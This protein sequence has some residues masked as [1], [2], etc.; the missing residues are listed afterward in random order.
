MG[1]LTSSAEYTAFVTEMNTAIKNF[2]ILHPN[3][4][5]YSKTDN[6]KSLITLFYGQERDVNL[7][8]I[9]DTI[10]TT[11]N[12][13]SFEIDG[14]PVTPIKANNNIIVFEGNTAAV[15]AAIARSNNYP[16]LKVLSDQE[17]S[18][19]VNDL[20]S[21]IINMVNKL[22]RNRS[23]IPESYLRK[24]GITID[25]NSKS[26]GRLKINASTLKAYLDE[27]N[28]EFHIVPEIDTIGA[29]NT[30]D[31][32]PSLEPPPNGYNYELIDLDNPRHKRQMECDLNNSFDERNIYVKEIVNGTD[33]YRLT[34]YSDF[35][36][37]TTENDNQPVYHFKNN[38]D[39][40]K[41]TMDQSTEEGE[42]PFNPYPDPIYTE[43]M[44]DVYNKL[45][46][47]LDTTNHIIGIRNKKKSLFIGELETALVER[48]LKFERVT[49][50]SATI[51]YLLD[52]YSEY[53]DDKMDKTFV[54][55]NSTD[56]FDPKKTYYLRFEDKTGDV[57][58]RPA[59]DDDFDVE[60]VDGTFEPINRQTEVYNPT[61]TYYV[62]IPGIDVLG[63]EAPSEYEIAT[64][65]GNNFDV[66]SETNEVSFKDG[67]T[68]YTMITAPSVTKSFS[69]DVTYYVKG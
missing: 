8:K 28:R 65:E 18:V 32:G 68:Y 66:D 24:G 54:K 38:V 34:D 11:L 60:Y 35:D 43:E 59:T 1:V 33:T 36:Q 49:N 46:D 26:Y 30:I 58:Y 52:A 61:K 55:V 23:S 17:I 10:D 9:A 4:V 57:T 14:L 27:L 45:L 12:D 25:E 6:G 5:K 16:V 29:G 53:Y 13:A 15:E 39:Y 37:E 41:L 7:K 44:N 63:P 20:V 40:Y 48:N 64:V 2:V 47:V 50:E 19:D 31:A 42:T 69:D 62:H 67:E 56:S 51:A 3:A 21:T 22:V